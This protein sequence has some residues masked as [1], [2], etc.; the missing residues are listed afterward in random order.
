MPAK[1]LKIFAV[2]AIAVVGAMIILRKPAPP[3]IATRP[4]ISP[5]PVVFDPAAVDFGTLLQAITTNR[6][7]KLVNRT[8]NEMK[9]V[10]MRSGCSCTLLSTNLL[11]AV[12]S[13][14]ATLDFPVA[15]ETGTR[16]G[17]AQT[18][19]DV[20]LLSGKRTFH[21]QAVLHGTVFPDFAVEPP[22]LDF[23]R[24]SP[25]DTVVKWILFQPK[26][27]DTLSLTCTQ[28]VSGP[29][30]FSTQKLSAGENLD[31]MWTIEI[32]FTAP[33]TTRT[34]IY[35]HNLPV[36]TSSKR[37]PLVT[38]PLRAEVKPL[39]EVRPEV[40]VMTE[41]SI[42]D[43]SLITVSSKEPSKFLQAVGAATGNAAKLPVVREGESD[44]ALEHRLRI[45][46]GNLVN[47]DRFNVQLQVRLPDGKLETKTAA[48]E[49][50]TF[51][52]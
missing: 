27:V 52:K 48:V 7:L 47:L 45:E 1:A 40:L 36:E 34:V 24:I 32:K 9:L 29:F 16:E 41:S 43:E 35:A 33:S 22:N 46:N 39:V 30:T 2:L 23:G 21:A 8:T 42:S 18:S 37:V 12:I 13:A 3:R 44:W 10:A 38:I 19:V 15:F 26:A 49:V 11:G 17:H 31:G 4:D 20:V 14:N 28:T 6:T 50:R 25:G 5:A 51:N